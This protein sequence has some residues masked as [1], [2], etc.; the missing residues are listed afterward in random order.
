MVKLIPYPTGTVSISEDFT[1]LQDNVEC[2]FEGIE[3]WASDAFFERT[4]LRHEK[5][6]FPLEIVADRSMQPEAYELAVEKDGIHVRSGSEKGAIYALTT[7]TLL[8]SGNQLPMCKISDQPRYSHRGV[9]LDCARHFFCAKEVKKIIDKMSLGK[10]NVLHWHLSD[11]QGWRIE[12]KKFPLLHETSKEYYTQNEIEEICKYAR[13]RGVE[14]IPEIDFPGHTRAILAAYPEYSCSK[15]KVTLAGSGGI[16]PIILCAGSDTTMDFLKELLAEIAPLFPGK[17]FHIGGDEAP[18]SEWKKCA[19]CKAKM[20]KL[21][22][23]DYEE[24]QGDF[25][26]RVSEILK[27]LGKEVICWNE[28]LRAESAPEDAIVQYWTL[29]YREQMEKA[30]DKGRKWIYSDMFELYLDYPHSMTSLKK[31][32]TIAPHLGKRLVAE[33][34]NLLGIEACIWAEHIKTEENLEKRL[35][36]RVLALADVSW[37]GSRDY[38]KFVQRL[39]AFLETPFWTNVKVTDKENWDPKGRKR[40][41]EAIRYFTT[42]NEGMSSE[43]R[44]QTVESADPNKEF[45]QSFMTKFFKP[46]DIPFLLMAMKKSR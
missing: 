46:L 11:D 22:F 16:Y 23:G 29:Q 25:S 19:H 44:E 5:G 1:I 28:T 42:I 7:V 4:G 27:E 37:N 43:V 10:L 12:S 32:Y 31:I 6:G 40:R 30:V 34:D 38:E 8:L 26:N 13:D 35:F 41:K 24:L 18:K 14:I 3:K 9:G 39:E 33:E 45:A 20:Y 36:P 21:G 15:E 17:Y 2:N